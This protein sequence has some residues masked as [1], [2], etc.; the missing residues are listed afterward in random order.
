MPEK[1]SV[2]FK[3]LLL[4][5]LLIFGVCCKQCDSQVVREETTTPPG[6]TRSKEVRGGDGGAFFALRSCHQL[7]KGDSGDF[8]SPDYMCSNPPPVV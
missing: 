6:D 4:I 2:S 3:R 5:F 7:L 1:N 8:Y